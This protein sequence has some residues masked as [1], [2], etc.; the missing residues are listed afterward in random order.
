MRSLLAR[1]GRR[2][3][4]RLYRGAD[5]HWA[6]YVAGV[7]LVLMHECGVSFQRGAKIAIA[8]SVPEGKGVASSA[9][10]EVAAILATSAKAR[11][12]TTGRE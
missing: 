4:A 3:A 10:L 5:D 1:V 2:I 11:A 9:A 12:T 7:F 8:S 6:A